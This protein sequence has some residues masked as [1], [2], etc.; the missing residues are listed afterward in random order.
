MPKT[1][2]NS[3][4]I[5]PPGRNGRLERWKTEKAVNDPLPTIGR[6]GNLVRIESHVPSARSSPRTSS[7]RR[8]FF[9]EATCAEWND[10]RWQLRHR[11][12]DIDTLS[13]FLRLSD[14]ER[15]MDAH[16]MK[17]FPMAITPYYA[18]LL[19]Q[20]NPLQPL[21]RT[22]VPHIAENVCSPGEARDPLGE[23]H[24]SPVPGIVHRYPDR[25]LFLVTKFCSTYCRYCTRSRLVGNRSGSHFNLDQWQKAIAYIES[26]PTVRDVLLS[27]G[28]PLTL[29]DEKLEWL[30]S[31]LTRIPHVEFLRIGT[32]VPVVLPQRITAGLARMLRRYHPLWISIH[33]THPDELTPEATQACERL[34]DAGIPL[35]SQTVLLAGVNDNLETMKRLMHGLLKI[36]VRPY[37]LYQ[38]DPI[39]GSAHFRTPVAKGMEII[40]GLRGHTTGYA[41]PTYVIDAPGGGGKIPLLPRYLVG[42]DGGDL[43]LNNYKGHIY[44]YPDPGGNLGSKSHSNRRGIQDTGKLMRIGI[45]YDLREDY[46]AEG[47]SEEETAEFD[48]E[49]TIQAIQQ[50]LD[51]LGYDTDRIGNV[52]NLIARLAAGDRWDVVFNIAEGLR[53]FGR[54]A[55]VP[56]LLEA[57]DIP[58]VFS[59]PMVLSLTL[60]K[61]VAKRLARDLGVPTPDFYV[62]EKES[63]VA[64]VDLPFPLFAKPV[65]EG[66]GKGITAASKITNQNQ[67]I[68]VCAESLMAYQQPVLVETFLPGREFTV[69]IIGSGTDAVAIGVLEVILR[70]NAEPDVYSYQ[71]KERYEDSVEYL[72]AN[73]AM[74]EKAKEMALA[75]WRGLG[76]RDAGRIDLRADADGILNFMEVN[77][78]PGLH[79]QHSDLCIIAHRVGMA[80][81]ALIEAIICSAITR[82]HKDH[83]GIG[84]WHV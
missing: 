18:S 63:D 36:R 52:K 73:D 53:G 45:T 70:E 49:D 54:E 2:F 41:V 48:R 57:Y 28:D 7:F 40:Q 26:T 29:P 1:T 80:Y 15:T 75:V 32:K 25:V 14:D 38:C 74:A 71:N 24:D 69:G 81:R 6:R 47:F 62:I 31:R 56:A 8:R 20:E 22:V 12:R 19:D 16:G 79:P 66:T 51:E 35:G 23:E 46:I 58:Y 83:F 37:Y 65:A 68:S 43:L 5:E 13:R 60:H 42:R 3:E 39:V 30:L 44:R 59:D 82:I 4:D 27:G 78:L 11:I 17:G 76:C 55:Q 33:F 61:G 34:A 9:P 77:P 50:T 64:K 84:S 10:W 67:L 21:R 72:L